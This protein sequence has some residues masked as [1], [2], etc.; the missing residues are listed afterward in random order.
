MEKSKV[1]Q[2]LKTFS[3]NELKGFG[4]FLASP[5]FNTNTRVIRIFEY[6]K[7]FHPEFTGKGLLKEIIYKKLFSGKQYN[8]QVMKNLISELLKLEKEFLSI[9]CYRNNSYELSLNLVTQLTSR[10]VSGLFNKETEILEETARKSETLSSGLHY[11]LFRMEDA[12]FKNNLYNNRQSEA[13]ES[14]IKSGEYLTIFF[15][16]NILRLSVNININK[17]SFNTQSAINLTDNL[18]ANLNIAKVIE[19]IDNN[20]IEHSLNLK[21]MY[22]A[23]ICNI[24]IDNDIHYNTYKELL[25]SNIK[26]LKREEAHNLLHFL[27]SICAQKINSGRNEYYKDLFETYELELKNNV[28]NPHEDSPLTTMKFRNIYTT[29]MRVG[30]HDWAERFINKY[31]SELNKENR[32]SI[33][34]LALAQ[35][36]FS[37]KDYNK[38]LEYLNK[39]KTEQVFYKVDVK[40]ISLKA[41]YELGHYESA[42]SLGESFKKLLSS[43][44][45]ITEQYRVR[46][47]N[48]VNM[49]NSIIKTRLDNEENNSEKLLSKLNEYESITNKNWLIEKINELK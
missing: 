40:T 29:A 24:E 11:V 46:N 35:L 18:L 25:Y 30:E 26:N 2:L 32:Q 38:T 48:F 4:D 10:E 15:L 43:N 12:K 22:Y 42:I 7:K 17:F 20:G 8:E 27:E 13:T 16:K 23:M 36:H 33:V 34:S 3:K 9:D 41:F 49:V 14:I 37:K 47:I 44:K 5:Y 39:V 31:K 1:T 45:L 28:Y 19:Y 21:L 6:L